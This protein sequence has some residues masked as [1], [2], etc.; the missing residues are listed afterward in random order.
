MNTSKTFRLLSSCAALAAAAVT[1]PALA[2]GW[3]ILPIVNDP[4]YKAEVSLAVTGNLV[5][6]DQG[7]SLN[8]WG[9]DLNMNCGLIQSPDK[10]IR[11]H[12]NFTRSN[13]NGVQGTG[14]EL[15]PRYTAPVLNAPGLSLGFG[16][17]IGV[18]RA[19]A[20]SGQPHGHRPR[21]GCRLELPRPA[22]CTPASTCV[23]TSPT[24]TV[25]TVTRR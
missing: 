23:T 16:P 19:E 20:D 15:S 12:V 3:Q 13:K 21:P 22:A 6:P 2:Q 14:F 7:G 8:A 1:L 9:L 25:A 24:A 17:S 4:G 11:T 18:F 10:R 5:Q